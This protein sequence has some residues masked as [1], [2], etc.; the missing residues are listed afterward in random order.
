MGILLLTLN[1]L[2]VLYRKDQ[3]DGQNG[4]G[5]KVKSSCILLVAMTIVAL[6]NLLMMTG[7]LPVFLG[8]DVG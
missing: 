8:G 2:H 6:P 5:S 7:Q 1:I 3:K 4:S